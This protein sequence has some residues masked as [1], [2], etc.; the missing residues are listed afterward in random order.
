MDA[1][2]CASVLALGSSGSHK[3][4]M[5]RSRHTTAFCNG[6]STTVIFT[7]VVAGADGGVA[8]GGGGGG[9]LDESLLPPPPQA[10]SVATRVAAASAHACR[11][12]LKGAGLSGCGAE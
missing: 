10:A 4:L 2:P 1:L 8:A 12:M 9:A 7:G 3:P 11:F 5:F 6:P